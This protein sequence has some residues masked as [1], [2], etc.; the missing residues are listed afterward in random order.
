MRHII[1]ISGKD[2]CATAIVQLARNPNL[3]YELFFSDVGS[4]LPETYQWLDKVENKLGIK[5]NKIGKSL[6]QVIY[7]E[8]ILPSP[9][10][11]FC[12]RIAKIEPME[13][14]IGN[15]DATIYFGIRADED[16]VGFQPSKHNIIPSYPLKQ[17]GIGLKEVYQILSKYE[18]PPPNFFWQKLHDLVSYKL[19]KRYDETFRILKNPKD[20]IQMLPK[21]IFDRLFSWRSR[22]NCY[23]CFFQSKWEWVGLLEHHPK[24]FDRAEQIQNEIGNDQQEKPFFWIQDYPLAKI[25]KNA[26]IILK[27]RVIKIIKTLSKDCL[28]SEDNDVLSVTSCGLF[29]GK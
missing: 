8:G 23:F 29:C 21:H 6:E 11:R 27:R 12:T 24:L 5:I 28:Y 7:N 4:E 17:M 2:S 20:R 26:N 18:L 14:W 9:K 15:D 16:R 1:P 13:K 22:S 3:P 10:V 25:R 19:Q